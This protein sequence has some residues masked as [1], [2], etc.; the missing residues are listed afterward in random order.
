MV[1]LVSAKK[2]AALALCLASL[3]AAG[4]RDAAARA[5]GARPAAAAQRRTKPRAAARRKVSQ[6]TKREGSAGLSTWGG[7]HVRLTEREGGASLEFDCAGGEITRPLRPDAE[8]RF[9]LPGT[10]T[11]KSPG[12]RRVGLTPAAR[13]ARYSGRVEGQTMTLTVTLAETDQPPETYT[14]TRGGAG[15]LGKCY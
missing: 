5:A 11:R 3:V 13:P 4:A 6:P 14:L 12:A 15:R 2:M 8:G 10:F 9:D 1:A 7:E